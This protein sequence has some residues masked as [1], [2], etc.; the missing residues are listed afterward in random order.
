LAGGLFH[1][2]FVELE[3]FSHSLPEEGKPL[4]MA[5]GFQL[6]KPITQIVM[7]LL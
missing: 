4:F 3:A 5:K 7:N 6:N 2:K 1:T